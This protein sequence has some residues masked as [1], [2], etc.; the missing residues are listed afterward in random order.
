M[1][2]KFLKRRLLWLRGVCPDCGYDEQL[3]CGGCPPDRVT[4]APL[5]RA[6]VRRPAK[7]RTENLATD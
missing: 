2:L 7:G 3:A 5:P 1:F 4:R 6:E